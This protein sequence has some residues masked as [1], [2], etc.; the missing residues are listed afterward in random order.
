M[1]DW[2]EIRSQ[3]P[4]TS[5]MIYLDA[6]CIVPSPHCVVQAVSDFYRNLSENGEDR[7][8]LEGKIESVREKF[9]KL[10]NATPDEVTLIKNTT[11]GLNIAANGIPLNAGD[12]VII[13]D[14]EHLNNVYPWL[15]LKERKGVEVRILKSRNGR[16]SLEDLKPIVDQ[17]TRSL[18]ISSVT[19]TGLKI[20]LKPFGQFCKEHDM[21]FVVDGIQGVGR[22]ALDVR[23]CWVDILACGGHKGLMAGRGIGCLYVSKEIIDTLDV[24][25]AGPPVDLRHEPVSTEFKQAEGAKKFDAGGAN[26]S[27]VC[28]LDAALSFLEKIGISNIEPYDLHLGQ[29][30]VDGVREIRGIRILSPIHPG[31]SSGIVSITT[32]DNRQMAKILEANNI[33]V[34]CR[35]SGIRISPHF[36]NTEEEITTTINT[37]RES[38]EQMRSHQKPIWGSNSR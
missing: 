25:F 11:E 26:Y 35:G 28:A 21:Y 2:S 14:L 24:T 5:R 23:D 22:L 7:T 37:V 32:Q 15:N 34:S 6:A 29:V 4:I 19:F 36:Y 31:E 3:F 12:N 13:T 18:S 16:L 17:R 10:I 1:K 9:A 20:D 8:A 33:Q 30:L 38:L 27:G